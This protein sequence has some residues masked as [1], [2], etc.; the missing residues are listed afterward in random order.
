MSAVRF[1][2]AAVALLLVM[3]AGP[4][5]RSAAR[6]LDGCDDLLAWPNDFPA[7]VEHGEDGR[8]IPS[9]RTDNPGDCE[10]EYEFEEVRVFFPGSD[11]AELDVYRRVFS[12]PIRSSIPHVVHDYDRL[13]PGKRLPEVVVIFVD[14]LDYDLRP[15]ERAKR[16]SYAQTRLRE[17]A[18]G[19]PIWPCPV[20]IY[21]P[22]ILARAPARTIEQVVAHELFH[23]YEAE[24][25]WEQDWFGDS[26]WWDEGTAEYFSNVEYPWT[27]L[28]WRWRD[29]L[30]RDEP[31]HTPVELR[32]GEDFLFFQFLASRIGNRGILRLMGS[33]PRVP[34][35]GRQL[36]ALARFPDMQEH[37][38]RFARQY[39]DDMVRDTGGNRRISVRTTIPPPVL[40][41]AASRRPIV[42]ASNRFVI[43]R[44]R[45][46]FAPGQQ[47]FLRNRTQGIGQAA[48]RGFAPTG[49][50]G[51]IPTQVTTPCG[52]AREYL[53]VLTATSPGYR[54]SI[55]VTD[56][57]PD[58]ACA[59][60]PK[61]EGGPPAPTAQQREFRNGGCGRWERHFP[62]LRRL[63]RAIH[64]QAR[65]HGDVILVK[66]IAGCMLAFPTWSLRSCEFYRYAWKDDWY[67]WCAGRD[68]VRF[69]GAHASVEFWLRLDPC[70]T[71]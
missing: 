64:V 51:A 39:L 63:P 45:I 68:G 61:P 15:S 27:D 50:W 49:P 2:I 11:P 1:V 55:D 42:I 62:R 9:G 17:S 6:S 4:G 26:D 43:T 48:A 53:L 22:T 8:P 20:I 54:L 3:L 16:A 5:Q 71:G 24:N 58:P 29:E 41:S 60:A 46:V 34:R 13:Q 69:L 56:A 14:T 57:K 12:R 30:K 28:E 36:D 67:A 44:R 65:C 52:Q 25:Y 33:M 31:G 32:H 10:L 19:G 38:H 70:R 59:N 37:F 35:G 18:H 40:I 47:Y 66:Y 7:H 23:C 21:T